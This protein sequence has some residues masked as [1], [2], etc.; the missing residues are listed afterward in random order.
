MRLMGTSDDPSMLK[1]SGP[2]YLRMS[3]NPFVGYIDQWHS[4][5]QSSFHLLNLFPREEVAEIPSTE[6]QKSR[7]NV[8]EEVSAFAIHS[9][10]IPSATRSLVSGGLSQPII[11]HECPR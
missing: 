5:S 10:P 1:A 9:I 8:H 2:I 4:S 3:P 11:F 6:R 7:W